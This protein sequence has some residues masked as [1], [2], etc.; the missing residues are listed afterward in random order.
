M[1]MARA[2][3]SRCVATAPATVRSSALM[4]STISSEAARSIAAVRG[5]RCSV[6][7]GSSGLPGG[8]IPGSYLL[9]TALRFLERLAGAALALLAQDVLVAGDARALILRLALLH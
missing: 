5:L 1:S 3:A 9:P 2:I 4:R 6:M 7:R 8:L